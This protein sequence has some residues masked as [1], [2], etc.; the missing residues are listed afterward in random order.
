MNHPAPEGATSIERTPQERA[1][2]VCNGMFTGHAN[3]YKDEITKTIADAV[4]AE[5]EAC[6][7]I[8]EDSRTGSTAAIAT[9]IR[10]RN[11]LT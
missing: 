1:Q 6:A 2:A 9:A 5:R 10:A 3:L 8:A 11:N 4:A 7:E